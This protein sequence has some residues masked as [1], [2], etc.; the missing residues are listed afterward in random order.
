[1][2]DRVLFLKAMNAEGLKLGHEVL[3]RIFRRLENPAGCELCGARTKAA[4][5][6]QDGALVTNCCG[7][8]VTPAPKKEK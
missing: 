2:F 4:S 5:V 7:A 3:E 6:A 8:T 1:M